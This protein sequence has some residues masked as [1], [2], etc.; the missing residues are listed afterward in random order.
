MWN[1]KTDT[2]NRYAGLI[3]ISIPHIQSNYVIRIWVRLNKTNSCTT[4]KM[5]F[6]TK[7]TLSHTND[8]T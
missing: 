6:G 8:E 5:E 7:T 3:Q 1:K 2:C 4:V